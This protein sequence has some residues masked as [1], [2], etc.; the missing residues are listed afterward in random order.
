MGRKGSQMK[1]SCRGLPD[2]PSV[3]KSALVRLTALLCCS[4]VPIPSSLA[5]P[6]RFDENHTS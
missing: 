6:C 4:A 2:Q 1:A 5:V 3:C